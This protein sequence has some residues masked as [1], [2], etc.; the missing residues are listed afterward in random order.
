MNNNMLDPDEP[1]AALATP[2]GIS[3]LAVVRTT[4][5][6]CI[7]L[8]ADVFEPGKRILSA[9]GGSAVYGTVR[10]PLSGVPADQV[11]A[12]LFRGPASYTGQDTVDLCCHGGLP[13]VRKVLEALKAAGFRDAGP[14]EFTMRAFLNGKLDLTKA[15]AVNELI[16]AKTRQAHD[17]AFNR[18]SGA[19]WNRIEA[20]KN[21]LAEV[22]SSIELT[23]DYPEDEIDDQGDVPLDLVVSVR[24]DLVR[25][26]G[27]YRTG[28]LFQEGVRLVLA[29]KNERR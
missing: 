28:R 2:W 8:I 18:L 26:S 15:E 16:T 12:L 13:A 1:I 23:L 24:E 25:L 10:H 19:V 21:T 9:A 4:G 17:M 14:G 20:S 7:D 27:T 29:G 5:S 3:A 6:G 22:L 11:V